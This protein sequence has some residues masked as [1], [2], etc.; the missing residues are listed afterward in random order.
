MEKI[1]IGDACEILN[2]YAFKSE[3]YVNSGI[4][5]IRIT[6]VQKGYVQDDNPQFYPVEELDNIKDYL[7]ESNDL[8][9]SLTGNV[10]RIALLG[11]EWLPAALNQRVAC[12]R[13][14]RKDISRKYIYYAL[15]S[16]KF[17]DDCVLS[18]KGIAQ[19][20]MSTE[21]LKQYVINFPAEEKQVEIIAI[22]DRLVDIISKRIEEIQKLDSLIKARFVE[23]F[24]DPV[25]NSLNWDE[26]CLNEYIEFLTSGSR[27]WAQ[28]FVDDEDELFITIKNVKNNHISLDDIQYI[29]AP[30]SKEAERTR[31]KT[32]DLLI[33]ITADLGRTGVV[34]EEI[35]SRGAYINQHLS[36]VRLDQKKVNPLYVSHFLET[37]G[38]KRQFESKNQNGV[39]AGL[40]FDAIKSLK[41]LV[42]PLEKQ[43]EYLNFVQQTD[44]LKAAVQ[45]SLDETQI[46]FDSLMQ[47]YFG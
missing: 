43:N 25:T 31:V 5:V 35:A 44:K 3:K 13:P 19:K 29:N 16:K 1:K 38:G 36:L 23:M 17:E 6:N 4:R 27:G 18:S 14:R 40:N 37:N 41:I 26:H 2:G 8:L 42:P 21:W 33:S 12:L 11:S 20:N 10:G 46:L 30:N 47:Q 22:L 24:G 7:L 32:G 45:K 9:L 28:Y 39:K 15:L 34:D